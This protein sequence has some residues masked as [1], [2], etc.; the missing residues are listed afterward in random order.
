MERVGEFRSSKVGQEIEEVRSF[1]RGTTKQ[2]MEALERAKS[3]QGKFKIAKNKLIEI[4]SACQERNFSEEV[5]I[6][7]QLG[8]AAWLVDGLCTDGD[9]GI[10]GDDEDMR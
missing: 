6:I 7:E 1:K 5:D 9:K 2:E 8:G 10:I 4:V 3:P